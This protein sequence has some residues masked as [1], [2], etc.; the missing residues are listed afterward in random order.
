MTT[1]K[2]I[3][4]GMEQAVND[5]T[6]EQIQNARKNMIELINKGNTV[7]VI[8]LTT[9][10]EEESPM[11]IFFG[12]TW[13]CLHMCVCTGEYIKTI[14]GIPTMAQIVDAVMTDNDIVPPTKQ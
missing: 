6:P 5:P 10:E 12:N 2:D 13:R 3:T 7:V 14:V 8:A 11:A 9:K 1:L 4:E